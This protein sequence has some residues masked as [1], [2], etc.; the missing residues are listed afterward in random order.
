[1]TQKDQMSPVAPK[2]A[3]IPTWLKVLLGLASFVVAIAGMKAAAGLLVPFLL[4]LFLAIISAPAMFWLQQRGIRPIVSIII[5]TILLLGI[6]LFFGSILAR[7]IPPL[8]QTLPEYGDKIQQQTAD[9]AAWV[10]S[11]G[12]HLDSEQIKQSFRPD[13]A[14][15]LLKDLLGQIGALTAEG[16][17]IFFILVLILLEAATFESKFN[18]A[19]RDSGQSMQRLYR[20]TAD[21]KRYLAV[22]TV[23]SLITAVL[24]TIWMLI[25][26]IDYAILWG[27]LTFMLTF[28]PNIGAIL[29]AIPPI[30]LALVQLGLTKALLVGIGYGVVCGVLGNFLELIWI[31]QRLGLSTLVVFLSL[32]FWGWVLGPV[33]MLLSVPLTMA[34]KIVLQSNEDTR[35]VAILLGSGVPATKKAANS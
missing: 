16:T 35:W 2:T 7:S 32:T 23:I 26:G 3:G 10:Q 17:L 14:I 34:V 13:Y 9:W 12:I 28:V 19:L 11:K 8:I 29:S 6:G 20:I 5:V 31:G 25:L 27:L 18:A 1:M 15:K 33:G 30:L 4:A 22:K 21:V 24:V